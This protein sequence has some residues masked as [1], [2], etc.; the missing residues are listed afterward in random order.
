MLDDPVADPH[1]D[2]IPDAEL[3]LP[4]DTDTIPLSEMRA[5]NRVEVTRIRIREDE[6][7]GYLASVGIRP[8]AELEVVKRAPFGMITV[9]TDNH[10]QSLPGEIAARI[11]VAPTI[12]TPDENSRNDPN[13]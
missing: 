9:R 5:G 3:N 8:D 7:F 2:P 13:C 4:D 6:Q 11:L 10:E 12:T 1:G